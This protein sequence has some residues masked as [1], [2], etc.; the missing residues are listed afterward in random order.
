MATKTMTEPVL[1]SPEDLDAL[2][3]TVLTLRA[4]RN[5]MR[6]AYEAG[7]SAVLAEK[8]DPISRRRLARVANQLEVEHDE[9]ETACREAEARFRGAEASVRERAMAAEEPALRR[10]VVA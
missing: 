7:V 5:R 3:S 8:D 9:A 6:T 4:A 1:A 10:D 2:K